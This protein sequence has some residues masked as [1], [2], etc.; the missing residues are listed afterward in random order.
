MYRTQNERRLLMIDAIDKE[1]EKVQE[2]GLSCPRCEAANLPQRKFCAKCGAPLWEPCLRCGDVCAAG[3]NFCGACG[4]NLAEVAAEQLER[5]GDDF[6]TAAEMRSADQID[7]ALA[8]LTPIANNNHPRLTERA[9]RAAQ[10]VRQLAAER[11]RQRSVA[12]DALRRARQALDAF[13]Y[14]SAAG[15][16]GEIPPPLR[17]DAINELLAIVDSRRR[18]IASL[19]GEL[20]EAVRERRLLD[21]PALIDRLL[22]LKP[23]HAYAKGLAEQVRTRLIDAAEKQFAAHCYDETLQLLEPIAADLRSPRAQ[24]IYR[25]AAELAFLAWDLR[26]AP[27]LDA[28][29]AAV[30]ERLRKLAPD[31][32]PMMKLCD[33]V[34]RR[35][36]LAKTDRLAATAAWARPPQETPLGAAIEMS[37]GLRRIICAESVSNESDLGQDSGRFAVACGL[38]LAGVGQ[39]ALRINLLAAQ[40]RGVLSRF[41]QLIRAGGPQIAWGLDLGIS[42]LKAVRLSWNESNRQ[43]IIEAAALVE[44]AKPLSHAVNEAEEHRIVADTL[45]KFLE[46]HQTKGRRVCV[47]LPGRLALGRQ[48]D[49]PP[50]AAAK[51]PRLVEFEAQQQFPFP[52]DQLVWDWQFFDDVTPNP[53]GATKSSGDLWR[54]AVLVGAQQSTARRFLEAFRR[55]GICV[56][57]LQTDFV[58]LHNFLAHEYLVAPGQPPTGEACGVAAALDIGCDVTNIVVSAPQSLWFHSCGVA[59]QSFTRALVREFKFS[60]AQAEQ[61]KRRPESVERLSDLYE[62]MSPVFGDLFK[63]ARQALAAYAAAQP[64]L[65]IQR[66]VGLGGGFALHGVHRFLRCG[67]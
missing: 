46:S 28:T 17:G 62:A 42:G 31:D 37:S 43:A 18:E 30:A 52:L 21:L 64:D 56:D 65:P 61:R 35:L 25:Q 20:R 53:N 9:A 40:Q 60:M 39:A 51:A 59:G 8:L 14:D 27:L 50:V 3:E 12:E 47:G 15:I 38:A 26:N 11:E 19:V 10:L 34:E 22:A 58:A 6:R 63:E 29:L 16:L 49:L 45:K 44:H 7:E 41:S 66:I 36:T 48:F 23:D 13:D 24:E 1:T 54:R 55:L 57:V 33:E 2:A 32:A 4:V 5:V 67:R